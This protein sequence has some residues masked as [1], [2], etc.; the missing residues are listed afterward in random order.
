[1]RWV[2]KE[3]GMER[4]IFKLKKLRCYFPENQESAFYESAFF[5]HLLQFIATQKASIHL[6]QTSKHLLIALDQVQS[7]DHARALL[8]RI[9]TA[10]RESMENK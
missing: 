1:L 8:E 4:I 5:Q 10:V 6:K 7:M 2:A 3:L 9:R